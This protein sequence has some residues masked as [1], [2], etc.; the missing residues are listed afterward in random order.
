MAYVRSSLKT[1]GSGG[2]GKPTFTETLLI[3]NS[4]KQES[5]TFDTDYHSFDFVKIV[6]TNTDNH[7]VDSVIITP[8]SIDAIFQYAGYMTL[9]GFGNNQYATYEESGLTWSRNPNWYR[10]IIIT[11]VYGWNCNNMTV[12]EDEIYQASGPSSAYVSVTS[13]DSFL[14]Y[15][16]V[17]F[18]GNSSDRSE[19]IPSR[20]ILTPIYT[21]NVGVIQIYS[22]FNI[23]GIENEH[24]LGEARYFRVVGIKFT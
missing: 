24:E 14:S 18:V 11:S 5:F 10:N 13:T 12:V 19:I 15:D 2:G 3:D 9:N 8:D 22:S 20:Q 17:L 7:S 21:G 6:Y 4:S 16:W 1:G 23:F